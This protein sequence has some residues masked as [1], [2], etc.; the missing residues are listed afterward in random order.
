VFL[1]DDNGSAAG[2]IALLQ[3][4]LVDRDTTIDE[5]VAETDKL[6]VALRESSERLVVAAQMLTDARDAARYFWEVIHGELSEQRARELASIYPWVD[7]EEAKGGGMCGI[8][9]QSCEACGNTYVYV[10]E[11]PY[12]KLTAAESLAQDRGETIA[13]LREALEHEHAIQMEQHV[14]LTEAHDAKGVK[15]SERV[16]S[17]T[18]VKDGK[19]QVNQGG[20]VITVKTSDGVRYFVFDDP[21]SGIHTSARVGGFGALFADEIE[22]LHG[23]IVDRD[24]TIDEAVAETDKLRQQL[25]EARAA[26]HKLDQAHADYA[27]DM[28]TQ[29]A[30]V[31]VD[32][33]EARKECELLRRRIGRG[34]DERMEDGKWVVTPCE[35]STP[36]GDIVV[37]VVRIQ[38]NASAAL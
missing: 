21:E 15:I 35:A 32:L 38:E 3:S 28:H 34:W 25:A 23:Q 9:L 36:S 27:T 16:C 7:D 4:M 8:K 13:R 2:Q 19:V 12:C 6:R 5:A 24:T 22:R 20:V 33:E 30:G 1:L 10:G 18:V 14:Q 37:G 29:L 31:K 11:C 17:W 26:L